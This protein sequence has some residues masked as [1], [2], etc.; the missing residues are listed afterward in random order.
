MKRKKK[1]RN[2]LVCL[3]FTGNLL[4]AYSFSL[5]VL[6]Y[7]CLCKIHSLLLCHHITIRK[8]GQL[9]DHIWWLVLSKFFF[10][11]FLV[12]R[13]FTNDLGDR[14]SIAG[15]VISI[16]QKKVCDTTLLN[17]LHYKVWIKGKV[18]QS[19][20]KSCVLPSSLL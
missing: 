10:I 17:T 11:Y 14:G 7:M 4:L 16:T 1:Y 12:G 2:L 9:S 15:R 18:K 3:H 19:R 13:V 6:C 20:E 5:I 8:H